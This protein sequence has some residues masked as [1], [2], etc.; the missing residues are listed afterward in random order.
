VGKEDM[1]KLFAEAKEK[2]LVVRPFR[3]DQDR[4]R[5]A[6][7]CFCCDDCCGYFLDPKEECDKGKYIQSTDF[8]NCTNC[9][10][11]EEVC[12]FNARS[13][14]DEKLAVAADRCYG[15]GLCAN[16]CPTG[17]ITMTDRNA[18]VNKKE[19]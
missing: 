7:I 10:D 17:C 19:V 8:D 13:M 18:V 1:T 14:V 4:T 5:V 12:Y 11:C 6:G 9:G 16:I 2:Y 15:C 3:D